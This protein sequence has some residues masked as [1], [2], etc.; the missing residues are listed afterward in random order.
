[1]PLK[2]FSYGMVCMWFLVFCSQ[3]Q[4]VSQWTATFST[5]AWTSFFL[6]GCCPFSRTLRFSKSW[7]G[8]LS[9]G[10]VVPADITKDHPPYG[11]RMHMDQP[12]RTLVVCCDEEKQDG[13]PR[14][15]DSLSCQD[16]N[17]LTSC[18]A[19]TQ[20]MAP[21]ILRC[22][23]LE[24]MLTDASVRTCTFPVGGKKYSTEVL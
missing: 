11:E 9:S 10:V 16:G 13:D 5:S 1:M 18:K 21:D 20:Q 23:K 14:P 3:P 12:Q 17:T 22:A 4:A 15:S 7:A 2:S 24:L 19:N 6:T 8:G